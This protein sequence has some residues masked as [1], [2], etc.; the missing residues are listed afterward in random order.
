MPITL[1]P[2][3]TK[4]LHG[5]IKRYAAEYLEQEIGDLKA[6]MLLDFCLQEIGPTIYNLAIADAQ[7]YFQ[8]RVIDLEGVCY[9]KEFG[10]WTRAP[11]DH[12]GKARK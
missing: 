6:G 1:S 10:Y 3:V 4:Q 8:E 11:R 2:E 9:E 12:G 7:K 5:S